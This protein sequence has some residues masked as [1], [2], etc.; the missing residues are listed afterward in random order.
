[1]DMTASES[2]NYYNGIKVN[3]KH[4]ECFVYNRYSS[5]IYFN[6]III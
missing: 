4:F 2:D 5:T 1:M 3:T 6:I